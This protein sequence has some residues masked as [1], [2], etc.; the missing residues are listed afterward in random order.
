MLAPARRG[1]TGERG[2]RRWVPNAQAGDRA[3]VLGGGGATGIAWMAGLLV[4]LARQ[5]L[6]L[7]DADTMVGTSAGAVVAAGART[8]TALEAAYDRL[9]RS[10]LE[11]PTGGFGAVDAARFLLAQM[12]PGD[13]R[14]RVLLGRAALR[15]TAHAR[16][17]A[18]EDWVAAIGGDLTGKPW[19]EGRLL[20]TAVDALTGQAVVFD[21][22]SG[23]PLDRAMAASCA[24]PGIYPPVVVGGRAYVDGGVR[25]VTN[26]DLAAGHDRV[27]CIAPIAQALHRRKRPWA[28]LRTLGPQVRSTVVV[29]DGAS[30]RA[31]GPDVLDQSR[32]AQAAESGEAQAAR[33]MEAVR[34]VWG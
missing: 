1:D 27:V 3:V 7:R 29:P 15:A 18:E 8:G 21:N 12:V 9:L 24:V 14:G 31:M 28:L 17:V 11:V 30:R 10:G 23:V 22:D 25:T 26:A 4:G 33:V 2:V 5:G 16:T 19:P 34:A 32:A 6:D 20:V 13:R